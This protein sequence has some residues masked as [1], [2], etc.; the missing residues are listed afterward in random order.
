MR[1]TVTGIHCIAFRNAAS[2]RSY[3]AEY[4]INVSDTWEFKTV[5][6]TGDVTGTWLIDNSAGVLMDFTL[7][8]GATFQTPAGVW[9][10]GNF[11]ASANQVNAVDN[12][13]NFFKIKQ[14]KL[15]VGSSATAFTP[16]P[17]SEELALCKRYYQ[18]TFPYNTTPAQ[19]AGS[20]GALQYTCLRAAVSIFRYEWHLPVQLR[21]DAGNGTQIF[22]CPGA[23]TTDWWNSTPTAQLS[24]ISGVQGV[25]GENRVVISNLQVA[26][27]ALTDLIQI[28]ATVDVDF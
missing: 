19:N 13:A 16:L 15:E 28:H 8:A 25:S 27:D 26:N 17:F 6:L 7:A 18:K 21:D 11:L 2:D 9:T 14:V 20:E 3:I 22:Y 5:T 23:A 24:G 1:G 4:T 12:A 10:A